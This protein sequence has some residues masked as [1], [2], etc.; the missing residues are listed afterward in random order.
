MTDNRCTP[1]SY[2]A[3]GD[4]LT[5]GIGAVS[6]EQH[7]VAQYFRHLQHSDHCQMRN[8]GVSGMRSSELLNLVSNSGIIRLLPRLSH[9]SI[10][11]GGCDFIEMYE[12]GPLSLKKILGTI[13]KVQDNVKQILQVVRNHNPQANVYLLGFYIPLPA[14]ELGV[15]KSS[16][17]VK[18]MNQNYEQLCRK[19]GVNFINPFETFYKRFEYF[20]DE[21][22]PNQQGY[23]QLAQ[24]FIRSSP[25]PVAI[26]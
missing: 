5:E 8:W 3:L 4:S 21:V 10:T 20:S 17:F 18:S 13:R 2:L 23:D 12:S 16:L 14:Y 19:F 1:V 15:K 9:L 26:S 7:F 11:T 6:P 24:L 22:H 25:H